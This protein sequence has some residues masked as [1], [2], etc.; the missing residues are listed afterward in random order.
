MNKQTYIVYINKSLQFTDGGKHFDF[1]RL[2]CKRVSTA[3]TYVKS[4]AQQAADGYGLNA[5]YR[6]SF[7]YSGATYTIEDNNGDIVAHG[8]ITDLCPAIAELNK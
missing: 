6:R 3:I 1:F 4:W 5:L 2:G 7:G 8:L